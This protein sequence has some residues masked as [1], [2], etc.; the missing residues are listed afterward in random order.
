MSDLLSYYSMDL[1][2]LRSTCLSKRLP[3]IT[4]RSD[5]QQCIQALLE[6]S[7]QAIKNKKKPIVR[8]RASSNSGSRGRKVTRSPITR[9]VRG[10]RK[11]RRT[12]MD[13]P[14][15]SNEPQRRTKRRRTSHPSTMT[16]PEKDHTIKNSNKNHQSPLR[17]PRIAQ[18]PL[19]TTSLNYSSTDFLQ[20]LDAVSDEDVDI[21]DRNKKHHSPNPKTSKVFLPSSPLAIV[22]ASSP[23]ETDLDDD[24]ESDP[25]NTS[26]STHIT[27]NRTTTYPDEPNSESESDDES[28]QSENDSSPSPPP[29][30]QSKRYQRTSRA[31]PQEEETKSRSRSHSKP[32][33]RQTAPSSLSKRRSKSK[34][35]YVR[36]NAHEQALSVPSHSQ[37]SHRDTYPVP[38]QRPNPIRS[39]P[40][41]PF[42]PPVLSSPIHRN[43]DTNQSAR[44]EHTLSM[45]IKGYMMGIW[46][47][48]IWLPMKIYD[49]FVW[50]FSRILPISTM[51]VVLLILQSPMIKLWQSI[52][53]ES[54]E[55]WI[56]TRR[57][58]YCDNTDH[59]QTNED[60]KPCPENADCSGG[61]L[62]CKGER[63]LIKGQC[64]YDKKEI[65]KLHNQM[66]AHSL[67][68]LSTR[69]GE[70]ECQSYWLYRV[71]WSINEENENML[72]N[73]RISE[74]ELCDELAKALQMASTSHLFQ[75][76]FATFKES[77]IGDESKGLEYEKDGEYYYSAKSSKSVSCHVAIFLTQNSLIII[78]SVLIG[79]VLCV[80][81]IKRRRERNRRMRAKQL[82]EDRKADVINILKNYLNNT[83]E[84]W[85]P[86][87]QIRAQIMGS[88]N[89]NHEWN[90]VERLVDKDANIQKSAQM[91]DGLQKLCWK[92]SDTALIH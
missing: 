37:L 63:R 46:Y 57:S 77:I 72:L 12:E 1:R 92:L 21:V 35:R 32:R 28:S 29:Q 68:L 25:P 48:I 5:R 36:H 81:L 34:P 64:L 83:S 24:S 62:Y 9:P 66:V 54:I 51:V 47:G 45:T 41:Q 39:A 10:S 42:A 91:V 27:P 74:K 56:P 2:E 40:I 82:M 87:A 75:N 33:Y 11:R 17:N 90:R 30:L 18:P 69:Y 8:R 76:V 22:K 79:I 65:A 4:R 16:T 49:G 15:P 7:K 84:R 55:R 71:V 70:Y 86:I 52:E 50:I 6:S 61:Y 60:C 14:T 59:N 67:S 43:N 38:V 53:F 19:P 88:N 44:R 78:P 3:G 20:L 85:I 73:K 31:Y 89:N 23:E 13:E 80:W 58:I 26:S